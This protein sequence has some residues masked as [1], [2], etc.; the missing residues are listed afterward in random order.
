MPISRSCFCFFNIEQRRPLCPRGEDA[1]EAFWVA[2]EWAVS[3]MILDA[4]VKNSRK[5]SAQTVWHVHHILWYRP[6]SATNK[7]L[8]MV[9]YATR[10]QGAALSNIWKTEIIKDRDMGILEICIFSNVHKLYIV[11]G[12]R[13]WMYMCVIG[14]T[15]KGITLRIVLC[16]KILLVFVN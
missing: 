13:W 14:V 6:L 5:C 9:S 11:L 2:L 4:R 16:Y 1:L 8:P 10:T 12:A 15:I 3:Q 7:K